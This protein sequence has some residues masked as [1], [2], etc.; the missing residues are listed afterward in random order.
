MESEESYQSEFLPDYCSSE[1]ETEELVLKLET[2]KKK[3]CK[4]WKRENEFT[5][6]NEAED[7]VKSEKVWS[8]FSSNRAEEG[9]KSFFRCLLVV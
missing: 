7:F 4:D 5:S 3:V 6:S 2:R 8:C 9:K 1:S